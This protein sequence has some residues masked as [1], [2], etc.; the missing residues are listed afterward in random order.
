MDPRNFQDLRSDLQT[1]KTKERHFIPPA[2]TP[3]RKK[4]NDKNTE[5]TQ[6]SFARDDDLESH[7][8]G[9]SIA[10]KFCYY[11]DSRQQKYLFFCSQATFCLEKSNR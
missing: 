9:V 6:K 11:F 2:R 3:Q 5:A 10:A 8:S 4:R 1:P 7:F